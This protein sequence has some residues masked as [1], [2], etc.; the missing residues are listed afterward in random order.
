MV[1]ACVRLPRDGEVARVL[2]AREHLLPRGCAL[3]HGFDEA[4]RRESEQVKP[5]E[6]EREQGA[7]GVIGSGAWAI[8]SERRAHLRHGAAS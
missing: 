8:G 7:S 5:G 1:R 6:G 2:P 3:H 4:G